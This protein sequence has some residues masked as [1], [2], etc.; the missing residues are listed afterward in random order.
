M[1][2]FKTHGDYDQA[3]LGFR[4]STNDDRYLFTLTDGSICQLCLER[5]SHSRFDFLFVG[6]F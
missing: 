5:L 6:V 2:G 1:A 3:M 4:V